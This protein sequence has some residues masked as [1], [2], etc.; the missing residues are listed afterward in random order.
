MYAARNALSRLRAHGTPHQS[1]NMPA[2]LL[3]RL[4]SA[5]AWASACSLG[6][7]LYLW[8]RGI[9]HA[10]T[11]LGLHDNSLLAHALSEDSLRA[12]VALLVALYGIESAAAFVLGRSTLY[13]WR[14][15]DFLLHHAPYAAVVGT[16][17]W[18]RLPIV[19][20]FSRTLPLTLLTSLNEA[21]A[22]AFA[23]GAPKWI[24]QPNRA[25]LLLLMLALIAV[26]L[27]ELARALRAPDAAIR[28]VSAL[29]LAAPLYH[30]LAVVPACWKRIFRSVD[31]SSFD[32]E[33]EDDLEFEEVP[34]AR[35]RQKNS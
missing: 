8:V 15:C 4:A 18:L 6:A 9:G 3:T 14:R 19:A 10:L 20:H 31:I 24:D 17:T 12:D 5:P 16:A 29:A 35:S 23:L 22:T 11:L 28:A 25:Y 1:G 13:A 34:P 30:A 26:E 7:Y 32:P 21:V 27:L 2:L 33:G